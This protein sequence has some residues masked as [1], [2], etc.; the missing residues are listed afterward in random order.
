MAVTSGAADRTELGAASSA[1]SSAAS[2]AASRSAPVAAAARLVVMFDQ[3]CGLC[4][5]TANR[6]RRWDR[7]DRLELLSLQAA[8][9]SE[10]PAVAEA[11]RTHPV[12]DELHVLDEA[13]GRIDAGG[14]AA[15]AIAAAMPGGQFVRPLRRLPPVRWIVGAAYALVARN[16][17]AIGRRLRLEGPDCDLPR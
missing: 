13:S 10:R 14:G 12:L 1:A 9:R 8:L 4:R 7:H 3:D 11:A 2:F 17:H 16:R 15:L 5:A 6:L